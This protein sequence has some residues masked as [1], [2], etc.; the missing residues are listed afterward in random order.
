MAVIAV[1]FLLVIPV[2][3]V[4][5]YPPWTTAPASPR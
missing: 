5:I 2:L 4:R 3:P 1:A